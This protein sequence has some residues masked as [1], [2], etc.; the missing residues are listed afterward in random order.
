MSFKIY[1]GVTLKGW[2]RK[3]RMACSKS[4]NEQKQKRPEEQG[5]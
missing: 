4:E 1:P 3:E 2:L 5:E